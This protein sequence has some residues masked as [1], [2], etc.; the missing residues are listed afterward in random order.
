MISLKR[1]DDI[2]S[3][4]AGKRVLVVGDVILDRYVFGSVER[5]SPEAPVPVVKVAREEIRLGGAGNVAANIDRL[6]G[7]GLLVGLA[8]EDG[9]ADL[10]TA[11][12]GGDCHLVRSGTCATIVKT[13]IVAQRQQVVRVDREESL[14]PR[15]IDE[16]RLIALVRKLPFD[17]VVVSDYAK[18]TVG[19]GLMDALREKC[20]RLGLPLLVDPKPQHAQFY[21]GVTG[22]TPNLREAETLLGRPLGDG[23]GLRRGLLRLRRQFRSRFV[24]VTRGEQGISA[25]EAGRRAFHLP[26]YSHEVFDVTG[27]GDTVAAVLALTLAAGA[28]LR[29]AIALANAAASVVVEKIGTWPVSATELRERARL[30]RHRH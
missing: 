27:A 26:A 16:R 22:I 8:G 9:D 7:R 18:G 2:C 11:A 29:E 13:R 12:K 3:A 24:V 21:R 6:G 14:H 23:A 28:D 30:I 20:H 25:A 5:I 15:A 19:G 17:G 4:F 10:I 1:V